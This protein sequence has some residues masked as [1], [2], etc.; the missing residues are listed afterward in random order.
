MK[1]VSRFGLVGKNIGYSLSPGIFQNIFTSENCA[2]RY[3]IFDIENPQKWLENISRIPGL[4][5]FNVTIPYKSFFAETVSE[6]DILVR[7][8]GSVNTVVVGEDF[9]LKGFNTDLTGFE[10][11]FNE[12]TGGQKYPAIILGDG[13]TAS[14]VK[15]AFA[16]LNIPFVTVSRTKKSHSI[17]YN[18]LTPEII[19]NHPVII[20]TTPLGSAQ[21]PGQ[22]PAIPYEALNRN[23]YLFDVIYAP[24]LTPF[25]IEGLKRNA[26]IQNGLKMLVYQAWDAWKIWKSH[27]K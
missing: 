10:K 3:N 13:A 2:C 15:Y 8:T 9:K 12:F 20:N 11:A 23:H 18:E 19:R 6:A 22:K 14:T 21:F 25:L 16:R 5:G 1:N 17:T 4:K 7:E 27:L 24:P 26:K